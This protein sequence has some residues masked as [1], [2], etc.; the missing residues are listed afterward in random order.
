M[1]WFS[2]IGVI[3]RKHTQLFATTGIVTVIGACLYPQTLG[4]RFYK[5]VMAHYKDGT[6]LP[7]DSETQVIID[8][9]CYFLL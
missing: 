4:L 8:Q 1:A 6:I 7:V 5:R 2:K 3:F 9:V